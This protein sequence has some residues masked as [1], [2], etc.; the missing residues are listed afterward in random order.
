MNELKELENFLKT[1]PE[2]YELDKFLKAMKEE[3]IKPATGRWIEERYRKSKSGKVLVNKTEEDFEIPN[4]IMVA[5][6][7]LLSGLMANEASFTA[8]ISYMALG[9]GE[10]AWDVSGPPDPDDEDLT[11]YDEYF[12]KVVDSIIYIDDSGNQISLGKLTTH[13][14]QIQ[15]TYDFGEAIGSIREIATFGGDATSS[16][17]SGYI[18]SLYRKIETYKESDDQII[19]KCRLRFN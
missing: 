10:A 1:K 14:I 5:N 17:D 18:S 3:S 16:V 2:P 13:R 12:R 11:L 8:G 6:K 15:C 9:H 4:H 7:A 19:Y